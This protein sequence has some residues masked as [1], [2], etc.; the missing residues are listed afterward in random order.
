MPPILSGACNA[1]NYPRAVS[2]LVL[3]MLPSWHVQL[4]GAPGTLYSGET[5]RLRFRFSNEYP[6]EAPE[7]RKILS[8]S[9]AI[10]VFH[11]A[12]LGD[13]HG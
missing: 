13:F 3:Q 8:L 7:V 5:Y 1:G 2:Y 11:H 6:M 9:A 10:F 12:V 4:V